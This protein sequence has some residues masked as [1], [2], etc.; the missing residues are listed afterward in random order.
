[1]RNKWPFIISII[2]PILAFVFII[3]LPT[4]PNIL[5]ILPLYIIMIALILSRPLI[6]LV[7][8]IVSTSTVF[9]LDTFPQVIATGDVGLYLPE[10]LCI[11]LTVRMLFIGAIRKDLHK[12]ASPIT[13]PMIALFLWLAFSV[14]NAL[15]LQRATLI[16]AVLTGRSYIYYLNFFLALYYIDSD[17]KMRFVMKSLTVI[18]F[19]CA[20]LSFIQYIAGPENRILPWAAWTISRVVP[21]GE[22]LT[23]ARVMPASISLI[24]MFFFPVLAGVTNG[25]LKNNWGYRLFIILAIISMFVSFTRNV[26]Y[27]VILGLFLIWMTF[28]GKIRRAITRNV[29]TV[30]FFV[31]LVTYLP[32]YFGVIKVPNWWEQV[33]SRQSET[34]RSPNDIE[35]MVWRTVETKTI[36][37]A[38]TKSPI[39][40]NGIGATYYHPMYQANVSIAHNGYMAIVFQL[41]LIGL[42]IFAMI[43]ICY[44]VQSI[45][46][47]QAIEDKYYRSIILG[48]LVV[49]VALLPAVWVKP[50][51]VLEHHWIS[52]IAFIWAFPAII[53]R[54]N[55]QQRNGTEGVDDFEKAEKGG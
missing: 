18:A 36:M 24:Y 28:R 23:L 44:V 1:M 11:F 33:V 2:V 50:V 37:G 16:N 38:I 8:L 12:E 21:E 40:G 52:L 55:T 46:V 42:A 25:G 5:T 17:E 31:L 49:F 7:L 3:F 26:Y 15:L 41:G 9:S 4:Q 43:F 34:V 14:L 22:D 35:T 29:I 39:L 20:L 13:L 51:L 32:V 30:A 19:I 47:Y 54:I 27:S 45:K 10:A 6:A 48:F 53:S